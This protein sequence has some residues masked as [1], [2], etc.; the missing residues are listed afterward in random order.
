[1]KSGLKDVLG[2]N[3][4]IFETVFSNRYMPSVLAREYFPGKKN[5]FNAKELNE[6]FFGHISS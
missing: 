2:R 4:D 6:R 1:M 3:G 5:K